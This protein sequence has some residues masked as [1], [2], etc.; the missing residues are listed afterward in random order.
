MTAHSLMLLRGHHLEAQGVERWEKT[1]WRFLASDDNPHF[2][3]MHSAW[4]GAPIS[5]V[6]WENLQRRATDDYYKFF[7]W[8]KDPEQWWHL[9]MPTEGPGL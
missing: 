5:N 3:A 7:S 2:A 9:P 8:E 6:A 1:I 4:S